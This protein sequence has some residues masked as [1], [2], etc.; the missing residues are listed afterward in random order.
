MDQARK[1][2]DI[3]RGQ[4]PDVEAKVNVISKSQSREIRH[5]LIFMGTSI[6]LIVYLSSVM[7][8]SN[9]VSTIMETAYRLLMETALYILAIAVF[10]GSIGNLLSEFHVVWILNKILSPLMRP[11]YNLPGAA[12]VGVTTTYLSDN[13][14][15]IAL[16]NDKHF[17]KHFKRQEIPCLCN[18]GTSFGMGLILTTFM[19][20]LGFFREA[21]IGNVGAVIGSIVSVRMMAHLIKKSGYFANFPVEKE[22]DETLRSSSLE[23]TDSYFVRFMTSMLEGGKN[24]L[25]MGIAI[26]P[27]LIFVCTFIMILTFGPVDPSIGYQGLAYEGTQ[28]L[29]KLGS[30]F[31]PILTPLFGFTSAEAIAF[32]VTSLGAVGAALSLIPSFLE[33]GLIGGNDIAVFTAMGMCW[34]GYLSTHVGM[35]DAIGHRKLISSAL[36]SHTI[37]GLIAGISAHFI[38]LLLG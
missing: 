26:I 5:S 2:N 7:G 17:L 10:M 21:L 15:I 20:G 12:F 27:G 14:A 23:S 25:K 36:I 29:P 24:G 38:F 37:G 13:P 32:P 18:L 33:R 9:F 35:M 3:Y 1:I 8:I 22:I 11:I 19:M 6:A 28:L 30:V 34:S 31:S 4:K 16:S